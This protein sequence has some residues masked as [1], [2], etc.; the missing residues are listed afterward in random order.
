MITLFY[1]ENRKK[2]LAVILALA[3][4]GTLVFIFSNSVKSKEDSSNQ[5]SQIAT[6]VKPI[7]DPSDN[8][9]FNV[10]EHH[11]RKLAHFSEFFI[12]GFELFLLLALCCGGFQRISFPKYLIAPFFALLTAL[13]DETIQIFS[14]RGSAVTDV[15]IDFSGS[16]CGNLAAFLTILLTNI[17]VAKIKKRRSAA[18]KAKFLAR[19]H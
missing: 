11:I 12:L 15:W 17:I 1:K 6:T 18:R 13:T 5:S 10:F 19:K 3:I 2:L 7:V 8:I 14:E 16:L 4:I 9:P